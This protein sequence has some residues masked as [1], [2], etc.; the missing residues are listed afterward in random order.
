LSHDGLHGVDD[1][2]PIGLG[3]TTGD[4][5]EQ[6]PNSDRTATELRPSTSAADNLV[7]AGRLPM[8]AELEYT[9]A[10]IANNNK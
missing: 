10:V 4:G 9:Q 7:N 5:P 1:I 6:R 8:T 2:G 3:D